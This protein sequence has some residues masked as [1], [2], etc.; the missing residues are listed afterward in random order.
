MKKT[1]LCALTALAFV[2]CGD[3]K[4]ANNN[5]ETNATSMEMQQS[6]QNATS[7]EQPSSNA[8]IA[9]MRYSADLPCAD[10]SAIKTNLSISGDTYTLDEEYLG[11]KEDNN[12][13]QTKFQSQGKVDQND[14][15]LTLTSQDRVMKFKKI[16]E[17]LLLVNENLEEPSEDMKEYFTFKPVKE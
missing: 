3:E 10:C 13:T 15:H 2:A 12:Q 5:M 17:N 9:S 14:T 1:L 11:V 4:A 6:E 8:N 7:M 16:D